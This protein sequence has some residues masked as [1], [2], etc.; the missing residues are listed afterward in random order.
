MINRVDLL[1]P[2]SPI[3]LGKPFCHTSVYVLDAALG[4]VPVGVTGEICIGG[5]GVARGYLN[6][7]DLTAGGS[8]PIPS[9]PAGGCTRPATW[10]S[11][12]PTARWHSWAAKTTR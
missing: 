7:P 3:T 8:C 9:G 10:A 5:S 11:G 2:G 6:L 1:P 4:L 12:C